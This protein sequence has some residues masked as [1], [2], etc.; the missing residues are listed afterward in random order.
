MPTLHKAD[1]E[2]DTGTYQTYLRAQSDADL[3]DIVCHL[4]AARYPARLDAARRETFR[5]HVLHVPAYT[6]AEY[7]IRYAAVFAI[8]LATVTLL[9]TALLSGSAGLAAVSNGPMFTDDLP[10]SRILLLLLIETLRGIVTFGI[11]L[12]LY[13]MLM[14]V[15]TWW[16]VSRAPHLRSHHARAD[17]WRC[18]LFG[19]AVLTVATLIAS[20]SGSRLP[21][22]MPPA[23]FRA[24]T[25]LD[26]F[27]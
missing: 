7:A 5:R 25:L 6:I 23:P 14:G 15:L 17:V 18:A 10:V 9:L 11:R 19:L 13:P 24:L 16:M 8:C 4:D 20:S 27:A 12:G 2:V 21:E 22:L 26:P 1:E 3:L